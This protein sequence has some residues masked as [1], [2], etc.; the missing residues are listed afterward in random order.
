MLKV[1]FFTL[2]VLISNNL[3]MQSM[4]MTEA[5]Q[6]K[7]A[8]YYTIHMPSHCE[9]HR[10]PGYWIQTTNH[11]AHSD[12]PEI[13]RAQEKIQ[14]T[15]SYHQRTG[16]IIIVETYGAKDQLPSDQELVSRLD[17]NARPIATSAL[18]HPNTS[19]SIVISFFD[20][21][22]NRLCMLPY[23]DDAELNTRAS[24][25]VDISTLAHPIPYIKTLPEYVSYMAKY[26]KK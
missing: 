9:H 18:I 10:C 11:C 4:E 25:H 17:P 14:C 1:K 7:G 21:S 2:I 22:F 12:H 6:I 16:E 26:N 19:G 24:Q 3:Y 13:K 5:N 20:A 15:I 23:V 8:S